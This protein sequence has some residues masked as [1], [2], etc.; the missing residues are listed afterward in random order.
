MNKTH[1]KSR[2]RKS[3]CNIEKYNNLHTFCSEGVVHQKVHIVQWQSSH[4]GVRFR[5]WRTMLQIHLTLGFTQIAT[6]SALQLHH[7]LNLESSYHRIY[8]LQLCAKRTVTS[9]GCFCYTFPQFHKKMQNF[10]LSDDTIIFIMRSLKCAEI[11]HLQNCNSA[12]RTNRSASS[13]DGWYV[14]CTELV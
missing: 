8:M 9:F 11:I 6:H 4:R 5:L 14:G 12:S 3:L 10:S 7:Y 2:T 13:L 1:A